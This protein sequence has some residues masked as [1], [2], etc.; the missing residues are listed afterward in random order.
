MKEG[1]T[2]TVVEDGPITDNDIQKIIA[3]RNTM[4]SQTPS[5]DLIS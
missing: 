3:R 4:L 1:V 5:P 2:N